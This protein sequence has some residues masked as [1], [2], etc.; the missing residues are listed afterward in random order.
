MPE[1]FLKLGVD[2]LTGGGQ[3]L[4]VMKN[5]SVT[6]LVHYLAFRSN[7]VFQFTGEGFLREGVGFSDL[8]TS[9]LLEFVFRQCNHVD[10]T[11]WIS[12]DPVAQAM[13]LRSL[14]VGDVVMIVKGGTV[15]RYLCEGCGWTTIQDER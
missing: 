5:N 10:D 14:S 4:F 6:V 8:A 1:T 7:V 2:F 12:K 11:E 3:P 9:D 15:T 13:R